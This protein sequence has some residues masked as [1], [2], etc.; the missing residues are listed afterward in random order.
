MGEDWPIYIMPDP[1]PPFS[2]FYEANPSSPPLPYVPG[3]KRSPP[4]PGGFD[5]VAGGDRGGLEHRADPLRVGR[6]AP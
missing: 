5:P 2:L 3:Y 4:K 1:L 6:Q